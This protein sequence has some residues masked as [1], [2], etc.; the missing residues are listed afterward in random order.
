[1][2]VVMRI[3]LLSGVCIQ[4]FLSIGIDQMRTRKDE[5][6]DRTEQ[7]RESKSQTRVLPCMRR[8]STEEAR[9][10]KGIHRAR[11]AQTFA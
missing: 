11:K 10:R 7:D 4:E 5:H 1:M 8:S 3:R 2:T 9:D 6:R